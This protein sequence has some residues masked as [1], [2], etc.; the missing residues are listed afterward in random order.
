MHI[1]IILGHIWFVQYKR[2]C[3]HLLPNNNNNDIMFLLCWSWA[4]NINQMADVI[5]QY[6]NMSM[7]AR[8]ILSWS[9]QSEKNPVPPEDSILC[10]I[11]HNWQE[12]KIMHNWQEFI[13]TVSTRRQ[14]SYTPSIRHQQAERSPVRDWAMPWPWN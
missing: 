8:E 2:D 9:E 3:V 6:N 1:I 5:W 11:M 10:K 7:Y 14:N 13:L 4:F 12:F